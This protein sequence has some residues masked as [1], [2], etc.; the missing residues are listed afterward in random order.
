VY[1][2]KFF[3][4]RI[5]TTHSAVISRYGKYRYH[6]YR[7]I[8]GGRGPVATFIM[9]NPSTADHEV[10]DPTIRRCLAFCRRWGCADLHVANLFAFRATNPAELRRTYDPVGPENRTYVRQLVE[11][12]MEQLIPGPV[13]CAWGEH[14]A[15]MDQDKTVLDWIA[16]LCEPM[17]LGLTRNGQPRHPLYLPYSARL[18]P[19]AGRTITWL[20]TGRHERSNAGDVT[21]RHRRPEEPAE[22]ECRS[23]RSGRV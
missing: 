9:L 16:D 11:K 5:M 22:A 2:F 6:L 14:G 20:R 23:R 7:K 8:D 21:S 12:A 10:D 13:V 3:R 4:T 1:H 15:F 17:C 19:F 18:I